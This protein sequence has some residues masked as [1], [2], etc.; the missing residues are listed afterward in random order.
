MLYGHMVTWPHAFKRLTTP[1][2]HAI[3]V[4]CAASALAPCTA[5]YVQQ[6]PVHARQIA[7]VAGLVHP[8]TTP[9]EPNCTRH[10]QS[11]RSKGAWGLYAHGLIPAIH[12]LYPTH[13]PGNPVSTP[14]YGTALAYMPP[15][16]R[17]SS[18][19]VHCACFQMFGKIDH[20]DMQTV[21]QLACSMVNGSSR[22]AHQ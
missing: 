11:T 18:M 19:N 5:A 9:A 22:Y 16:S 12:G 20:G 21:C 14:A 10:A 2:T 7:R 3:G 8:H 17:S 4:L 13:H 15:R 1:G 6:P